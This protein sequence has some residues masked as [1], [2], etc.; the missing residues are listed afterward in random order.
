MLECVLCASFYYCQLHNEDKMKLFYRIGIY[1]YIVA[2]GLE[3]C[4]IEY[5]GSAARIKA[6]AN[7]QNQINQISS[8]KM[9]DAALQTGNKLTD[10]SSAIAGLASVSWILSIGKVKGFRH[11][12]PLVLFIIYVVFY[13]M[14]V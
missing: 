11:V 13:I 6:R 7:Q 9:S 2:I 4:G 12:I 14:M 5:Y 3:M 8:D 1:L 10:I